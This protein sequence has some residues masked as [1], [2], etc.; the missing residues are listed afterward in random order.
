MNCSASRLANARPPSPNSRVLRRA[1][2]IAPSFGF[3]LLFL[4]KQDLRR[5]N[6]VDRKQKLKR[7]I[8]KAYGKDQ[9]EIRYVE[10]F[11][12]GGDAV[13]KSACLEGIVSKRAFAPYASGRTDQRW[14]TSAALVC[15]AGYSATSFTFY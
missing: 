9:A 12:T 3:D 4:G 8:E 1:R 7:L 15:A 5:E 11:E 6:L 10:H 2:A 13:L 14:G